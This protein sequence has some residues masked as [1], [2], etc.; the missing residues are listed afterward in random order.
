MHTH[1]HLARSLNRRFAAMAAAV[2]CALLICAAGTSFAGIQG[3][4][5]ASFAFGRITGFGSIFV[6]GVEYSTTNAQIHID[7]QAAAESQ[8]QVGQIVAVNGDLDAGG[9]QGT[10][11]DVTFSG[12]VQGPITQIDS[13]NRTFVVLGQTVR[14]D[15]G[16]MFGPGI[17][18]GAIEGLQSG[19]AVEVS[20]FTDAAGDLLASRIDLKPGNAALRVKGTVEALD[21]VARTFRI[22]ALS[23]DYS[24]IAVGAV[25]NGDTATVQGSSLDNGTLRA[26]SV[27]LSAGAGGS[28]REMGQIEGLITSFNSTAD[29]K[30]G[31][32]RVSTNSGTH[33]ALHGQALGPDAAV[34]VQGTFDAAGELV[35]SKV[36]SKP[37]SSQF[38]RG[39]VDSVSASNG[40][41]TILGINVSVTAT[42]AVEDDS[43]QHLRSFGLKDIRAGDYVEVGGTP[44]ATGT[45]L[46]AARMEREKPASGAELQGIA[47]NVAAPNFTLLGVTVLT[48]ARTHFEGLAAGAKRADSFFS[49]APDKTVSVKG[50]LAGN[51]LSA[52]EVRIAR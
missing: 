38:A 17:Q 39:P 34:T 5:R 7:D 32:Q 29:F 16:T 12:D 36:Q 49:E 4:G 20:A 40:T 50:T 30:V 21:P 10:A 15:A 23:V 35:A 27:Q 42:T 52:D 24:A 2:A 9:T 18:P 26:A 1:T 48:S 31:N 28:A 25:D 3:S 44:D 11:T 45:G 14:V 51:T 22:N 13:Q 37:R 8:L 33:F 19:A 47:K 43:T 46:V 41:L 6:N